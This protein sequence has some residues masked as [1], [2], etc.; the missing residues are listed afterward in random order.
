MI[1]GALRT[2]ASLRLRGEKISYRHTHYCVV[3]IDAFILST[4]QMQKSAV[5]G[6]MFLRS[7]NI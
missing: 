5:N 1:K 4:P 2:F 3:I 6:Y 7:L